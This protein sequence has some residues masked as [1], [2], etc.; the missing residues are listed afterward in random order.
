MKQKALP[1]SQQLQ[2][3]NALKPQ[4][5]FPV[6]GDLEDIAITQSERM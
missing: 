1:K 3:L 2:D 5:P 6:I 4:R